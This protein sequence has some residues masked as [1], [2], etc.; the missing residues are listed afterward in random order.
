M[1]GKRV[2]ISRRCKVKI[3]FRNVDISEYVESFKY[4]DNTDFTDDI[5]VVLSDRDRF[6]SNKFFPETGDIITVEIQVMNWNKTDDNRG[7]KL[8]SFE[9]DSINYNVTKLT[10]SAVAVPIFSSIRDEKNYKT[11]ENIK[12]S[13]VAGDIAKKAGLT[14]VYESNINPKYDKSEQ[15]NETDLSFL[16][17][18]CKAEG[19][20]MKISGKQLVVFDEAKYD[21]LEAVVNLELGKSYFYGYPSFKRNAK[22]IYSGCEIK[23]FDSKTD[24]TYTGT[25]NAPN[26][27][28]VKKILKLQE[29]FNS[30]T[31]TIDYNRK[32]KARLREQNKKE[33]TASVKLKGDII[34]FAG[35]NVNLKGF[36]KFDG[37]YNIT[38]CSHSISKSGYVVTLDLRKC[39]EGY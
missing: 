35:T 1:E 23:Y 39:L 6:W 5:S 16:E 33:W 30:E 17:K 4:S 2:M 31:D 26:M 18:L 20:A 22:N 29:K 15:S 34:Y 21:T 38:T 28:N 8:G 32:A 14:L 7:I 27:K 13:A 11:W 37:K 3:T 10:V 12:L 19:L 25:F 24:K 36:Y 9:V